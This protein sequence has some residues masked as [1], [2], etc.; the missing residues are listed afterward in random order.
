MI[1]RVKEERLD[2]GFSVERPATGVFQSLLAPVLL[3]LGFV[4]IANLNVLS[5]GFA[6]DDRAL[7]IGNPLIRTWKHVPGFFGQ[8]FLGM[9]YRPVVM[10]S[11][12]AEYALWGLR[13]WGYHLTNL[14]LHAANSLMVFF[15][16]SGLVRNR[17]MA[18]IAALL[19]AV[20]PAHKGVVAIADRTGILSGAFFLSTLLLYASCRRA[21]R[22]RV[23]LLFYGGALLS[24]ALAFFSKEET[25]AL[26][27]ILVVMDWLLPGREH[28]SLLSRVVP[29]I[30]F[31]LLAIFY[32]CVRSVVLGGGAGLVSSFFIEPARRLITVPAVLLDYMILL[33]FPFHLDYEP[34]TPLGWIGE[35]RILIALLLCI[36]AI[37]LAF[38]VRKRSATA[39]GLAWYL[40]VFLPMSNIIP[41]YPE[42]AQS[43]LFTPIHF[44]YL[45]SIG[46]FLCAA[47]GI[48]ALFLAGERHRMRF[49]SKAA[50][51]VPL[52]GILFFFAVLAL[53]RNFIWG[54]E[55]RLYR[56][57]VA[58]HPEN[59][60]M[61]LNLGNVY[62]ER[63]RVDDALDQLKQ[64]VLLSP[65][66]PMFRNSLALAYRDK[67]WYDRAV[68]ELR[69]AIALDPQSAGSYINLATVRRMQHEPAKAR[70]AALKAVELAPE[71]AV[72]H[73]TLALTFMD[74]GDLV[75]AEKHLRL[76]VDLDP[77]SAEAHVGLGNLFAREKQYGRAREQWQ[78]ALRLKPDLVEARDN[79][80]KLGQ[81]GY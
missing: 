56:Y 19:F 1:T 43:H 73:T 40:I 37:M 64:A 24:C 47:S 59:P 57:I 72:A 32:V 38:R 8:S 33:I 13:P 54:D 6:W 68:E 31:F 61:R 46:V 69:Q 42:A 30:P 78:T 39:F 62:L 53:Q 44:L 21:A 28:E 49:F 45:P 55:V 16:L 75:E 48:E 9:Y 2:E 80:R 58:M 76:A 34:R 60:R 15:L 7:I 25:L 18:F 14:L 35:P 63:G 22:G 67:G 12:V 3:I 74:E 36:V 4:L 51:A 79:L 65:D 20:H 27:L 29:A 26:P 17:R 10:A 50:V 70:A 11:F 52:C 23:S 5:A 71:S 41:I 81:M 66:A 77:A